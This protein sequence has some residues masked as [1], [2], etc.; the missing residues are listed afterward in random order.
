MLE[1]VREAG[2]AGPLVRASDARGPSDIPVPE[3]V[4]RSLLY[5]KTNTP[6]GARMALD[7]MH[8]ALSHQPSEVLVLSRFADPSNPKARG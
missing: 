5:M 8:R 6:G 7:D 2:D 4:I 1:E 3:L